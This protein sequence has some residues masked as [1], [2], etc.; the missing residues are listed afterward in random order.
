MPTL[1]ALPD[2]DLSTRFA[3]GFIMK[4]IMPRTEPIHLV[5]LM[6]NKVAFNLASRPAELILAV[7]HGLPNI[8]MGQNQQVLMEAGKYPNGMVK[9]KVI[10][11]ISC[12]TGLALG[13][14]MVNNGCKSFWGF[15]D[16]VVWPADAD[17]MSTP[18]KDPYSSQY[19]MPM[20]D[21]LNALLDGATVSEAL[22]VEGASYQKYY[23]A[24]EDYLLRSMI[25][26][27]MRNDTILGDRTARVN[28]RI[29]FSSPLDPFPFLSPVSE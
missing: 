13:P 9:G 22:A 19:L 27:N 12:Q 15:T 6:D 10:R 8:L 29:P 16:D 17:L 21:G 11:L 25:S 5:S 1:V 23:N 24:Q 7:G 28:K 18:W 20:V 26:F 2:S 3:S 4:Y 14:D